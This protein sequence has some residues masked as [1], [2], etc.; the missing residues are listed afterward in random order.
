MT[1]PIENRTSGQG[2]QEEQSQ[3]TDT[4]NDTET[5]AATQESS[6]GAGHKSKTTS[7]KVGFFVEK[8]ETQ[9]STPPE[10]PGPSG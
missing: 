9:T 2:G 3:D 10:Y 4:S 6:P 5:S 7:W 8:V 1:D